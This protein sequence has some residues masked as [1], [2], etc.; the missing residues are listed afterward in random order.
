[1]KTKSIP[2]SRCGCN[3]GDSLWASVSRSA[4]AILPELRLCP[5]C[6]QKFRSFIA[7]GKNLPASKG[8]EPVQPAA[9]K[10]PVP[11][12]PADA[13]PIRQRRTGT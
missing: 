3:P 11:T 6:V 2:C 4:K 13:V 12:S 1:M 8:K 10:P 7:N 9:V 5:D